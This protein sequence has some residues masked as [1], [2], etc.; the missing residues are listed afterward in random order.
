MPG[1]PNFAHAV[2]VDPNG[3]NANADFTSIN[4]AIPEARDRRPTSGRA[5]VVVNP[6]IYQEN[7]LLG[8]D[9][10]RIDLVGVDRDACIIAPST[11]VGLTIE[12]GI[13]SP[14]DHMI[15]GLTIL[16]GDTPAASHGIEIKQGSGGSVPKGI[17][18]KD[19][20]V[21]APGTQACGILAAD[22]DDLMIDG[23]TVQSPNF[24]AMRFGRA[25]IMLHSSF[26]GLVGVESVASANQPDGVRAVGCLFDGTS[27]GLFLVGSPAENI[28][29][30]ECTIRSKQIPLHTDTLKGSVLFVNNLIELDGEADSEGALC[31][32]SRHQ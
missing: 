2:V 20:K 13:V 29:V 15:Q 23:C 1:S 19:C 17:T 18:I 4:Q 8:A 10:H 25:T 31:D 21:S 32:P 22:A 6:G 12:S 7:V 3:T 5:T 11:G 27:K 26:V 9:D 16:T 30:R 28:E 14:R 24:K